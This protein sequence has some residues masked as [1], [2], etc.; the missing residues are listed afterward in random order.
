MPLKAC[1]TV[2]SKSSLQPQKVCGVTAHTIHCEKLWGQEAMYHTNCMA[3]A[4]A[5]HMLHLHLVLSPSHCSTWVESSTEAVSAVC[6]LPRTSLQLSK[7]CTLTF[8]SEWVNVMPNVSQLQSF[9][10][11]YWWWE[12][13]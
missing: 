10:T 12:K 5:G 13:V 11:I 4:T 9:C 6:L 7:T 2:S 3:L 1:P 8:K